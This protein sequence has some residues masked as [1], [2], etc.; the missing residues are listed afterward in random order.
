MVTSNLGQMF[1]GTVVDC[2]LDYDLALVKIE[3]PVAFSSAMFGVSKHL[4]V[5]D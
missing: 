2:D 5:G 4:A 1:I 3:S